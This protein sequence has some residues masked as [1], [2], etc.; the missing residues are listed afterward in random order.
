[1]GLPPEQLLEIPRLCRNTERHPVKSPFLACLLTI[2][3]STVV[4]VQ[5][6]PVPLNQPLVTKN[7]PQMPQRAPFAQ[8]GAEGF[9]PNALRRGAMPLQ[10]GLNFASAVAYNSGGSLAF[11]VAVADVNGDGKLD[12][13]VVNGCIQICGENPAGLVGVLLGNGDG[14]FQTVVTYGSGGVQANSIAVAD[15]NGDGKPDLLVANYCGSSSFDC[16]PSTAGSVGVLLGNGDGTFQ[17]AVTYGSGGFLAT[18]VTVA[19]VNGDEIPDLVVANQ[20]GNDCTDGAVGVLLGNGDGTFQTAVVYDPGGTSSFSI[21]VA[22]VNDDGKPDVVVANNS[23]TV[24]V[25]LG[26]GDGTF[27]TA[28]TYSS[29]GSQPDSVAVADVNGD[30]KPDILVANWCASESNCSHGSVSVLLGNGD[31]TFQTAVAY[32]SGGDQAVSV[33]VA[34]VNGDGKPDLVV[35]NQFVSDNDNGGLVGV[36]L[37]NGDG[38]FQEAATYGSGGYNDGASAIQAAAAAAD[39][40]RDGKPD[41]L[42]A[43]TFSQTYGSQGSV[44]VLINTSLTATTTVVTSSQNPSNFGQA[45]TFTATVT[46]QPGF[47]KGTPTGTVSFFDGITNIGNSDINSAGA[48]TLMTSTL[49]VGTHRVTA[50]YN[51]D[52]NF[53]PSTSPVLYQVVQGALFHSHHQT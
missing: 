11:S 10:N 25:L 29:G 17:T 50:I 27:Q 26:N 42:V 5:S 32:G 34:D 45:V 35:A 46:A 18:A 2:L 19:D 41:L 52:T 38:T 37:G 33:V 4:P 15:V 3:L 44:G 43:N 49:S 9:K 1:M 40:N 53:A 24:G 22:D 6:N 16:G 12:L 36:L 51:G 39:V 28:V 14:T 30:G 23:G 21:A 13:L 7:L 31:G 47:Y 8:R 48:A 20:C